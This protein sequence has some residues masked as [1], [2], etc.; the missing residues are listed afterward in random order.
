MPQDSGGQQLKPDSHAS[1][2]FTCAVSE[3]SSESLMLARA[4]ADFGTF[5]PL[6][7]DLSNPRG[8]GVGRQRDLLEFCKVRNRG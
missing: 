8:A 5:L 7:P 2:S 3:L 6:S 1:P 4:D